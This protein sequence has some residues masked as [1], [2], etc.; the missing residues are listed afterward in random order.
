MHQIV[1]MSAL[2]MHPL[3]L[4]QHGARCNFKNK[5]SEASLTPNSAFPAASS[6][7]NDSRFVPHRSAGRWRTSRWVRCSQRTPR[8][9]RPLRAGLL[10]R[11]CSADPG[12]IPPGITP[13]WRFPEIGGTPKSSIYRGFFP[14]KPTIWDTPIYG[15][16]HVVFLGNSGASVVIIYLEWGE[17]YIHQPVGSLGCLSNTG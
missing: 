2:L 1:D 4:G 17:T 5:R 16:P 7:R 10:G 13:I 3:V 15:N 11:W 6:T 8:H 12:Q 14:D 9:R